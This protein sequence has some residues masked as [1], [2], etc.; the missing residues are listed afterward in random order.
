MDNLYNS[1]KFGR[2]LLSMDQK[3]MAYGVARVSGRGIPKCVLQMEVTKKSELENVP[4]TVKVAMLKGDSICKPLV[5]ISLYNSKHVY[6]L[7]TACSEVKWIR[8]KRKVWHKERK[9]Y[10]W[11]TFMR[12]N[13]INFH[14]N[15]MG[16]TNTE[17]RMMKDCREHQIEAGYTNHH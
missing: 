13:A 17:P 15:N 11:I 12:L 9:E 1:V 5:C 14:N 7:T 16:T 4:N 8:K 6:I 2:V 10:V 3:V